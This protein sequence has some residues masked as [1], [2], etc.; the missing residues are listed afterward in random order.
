AGDGRSA[1]VQAEG[2]GVRELTR[3]PSNYRSHSDLDTYLRASNVTG[4]EGIDTRALVRRIRV[5]GAMNGVLSTAD[6]DDAS[7]VAKARAFPSMEGQDLV[8]KVV[9]D[10]AFEWDCKQHLGPFADHILPARE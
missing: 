5:R 7:L 2:F 1:A 3:V 10:R 4:I 6:L 8:S 9:P